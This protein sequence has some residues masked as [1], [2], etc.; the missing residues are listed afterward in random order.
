MKTLL[1]NPFLTL[2]LFMIIMA[3]TFLYTGPFSL[4]VSWIVGIAASSGLI[5]LVMYH[6]WTNK[7]RHETDIDMHNE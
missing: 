7:G 1:N 5:I 3:A 6:K 2:L 4:L